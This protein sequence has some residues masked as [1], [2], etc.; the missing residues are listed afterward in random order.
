MCILCRLFWSLSMNY[1]KIKNKSF[2]LCVHFVGCPM[3]IY[4]TFNESTMYDVVNAVTEKLRTA[5]NWRQQKNAAEWKDNLRMYFFFLF[6]KSFCFD[7]NFCDVIGP[8]HVVNHP[9]IPQSRIAWYKSKRES[10]AKDAPPSIFLWPNNV[11]TK[12]NYKNNC[13]LAHNP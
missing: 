11:N 7:R 3:Y 4:I 12:M 13:L 8:Y 1:I 10:G 2:K 9:Q 5:E 6:C